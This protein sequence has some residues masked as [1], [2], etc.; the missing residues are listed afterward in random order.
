[1]ATAYFSRHDLCRAHDMGSGHPESP[2][3]LAAIEKGLEVVGIGERLDRRDAPAASLNAIKRVH[4]PFYVDEL[5]AMAPSTGR[6]PLDADTVLTPHSLTAARH[7]CGAVIAA[8]D[9]VMKGEVANAF[10]AVRPPGHHAEYA[11]AMGFCFFDNVAV[12]AAHAMAVYGL[13]RVAILDFDVHHGNGTEDVFRQE[14]RVLFCSSYQ[15]PLFPFT[16]SDTSEPGRLIKTPLRAGTGGHVFRNAIERD[17]LPAL[18]AQ[19]PELILISAGFDAHRSDPLAD[20]MLE[21]EDF[22]WVTERICEA[23]QNLCDGRVVSTLEGGYALD[24]LAASAAIHVDTLS[25]AGE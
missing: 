20:L 3:R 6:I 8:V 17:W 10:C 23:A 1:M 2:D 16:A 14:P 7:G 15:S 25:R 9:A 5:I 11:K 18:D 19:Q 22:Q 13:T 12:G 4:D 21:A 24:A